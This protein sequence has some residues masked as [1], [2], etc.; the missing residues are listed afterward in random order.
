MYHDPDRLLYLMALI[1]NGKED[2]A[3]AIIKE[4]RKKKHSCMFRSGMFSDSYTYIRRWCKRNS[5]LRLFPK[6]ILKHLNCTD[7]LENNRR[8]SAGSE[9]EKYRRK[10]WYRLLPGWVYLLVFILVFFPVFS[11]FKDLHRRTLCVFPWWLWLVYSLLSG[12]YFFIRTNSNNEKWKGLFVRLFLS[13][14]FGILTGLTAVLAGGGLF[15]GINRLFAS[16]PIEVSATVTYMKNPRMSSG[17]SGRCKSITVV[18][19]PSENR[20]MRIDDDGLYEVPPKSD[21]IITYRHGL[22]G[23]DIFDGFAYPDKMSRESC[24]RTKPL[25]TE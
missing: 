16:E 8:V 10:P 23:I 17:R 11:Y 22:F 14:A 25:D 1:H 18:N 20:M 4:A 3:L 2:E 5:L 7:L 6:W 24:G 9:T 19:I 13:S 15:E 12:L 21:V